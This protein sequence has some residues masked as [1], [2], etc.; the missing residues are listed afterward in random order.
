MQSASQQTVLLTTNRREKA[1]RRILVLVPCDIFPPV[2]GSSTA[3]YFT[4]RYLS[5]S[6]LVNVLLTHAYSQG[7]KIDLVHPNLHIQYCPET[8]LDRLGQMSAMFNP[9]FFKESYKLMENYNTDVIQCELLW[10]MPS[11]ILLK[12]KFRKPLIFVDENVEYLKFKEIGKLHYAAIVQKIEKLCCEQADMIIAVSEIDKRQITE[13]FHIQSEKIETIPH[14]VDTE[15]FKFS[16]NG[17]R[18]IRNKYNINDD[19]IVLTF[20]GKLDYIPNITAVRYVAEKIHP[21]VIEKY[22]RSKFFIIGQNYQSLLD[23]RRS[24]I[25]FT[26]YVPPH[27]LPN[28]LSASDIVLVPLDSGSGT[29]LK[30]LEAASCSRSMVSTQKGVEGQNFVHEKEIMLTQSVDN[31]FVDYVLKLMEN[32]K[33]RKK[34]GRNAREK[35]EKQYSWKRAVEKFER[36][37]SKIQI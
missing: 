29:R 3:A 25:I 2:H 26:G 12:K 24:N 31:K 23:Y 37:Y 35:I 21:A 27:E 17:R 11:G 36:V 16:E 9:S 32:E 6:N 15:M 18:S 22:P 20:V 4:V 7:G 28:Y 8:I 5:E 30:T 10:S 14:C 1:I 13:T 19:S 33:L 34:I